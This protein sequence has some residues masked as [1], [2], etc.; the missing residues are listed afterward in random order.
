MSNILKD[1]TFLGV[2][3]REWPT[4]MVGKFS[5]KKLVICAGGA[6]VWDDLALLG[7]RGGD[8]QEWDVMCVNDVVMHYPGQVRHFFSNDHRLMPHWIGA[9]RPQ[10][11]RLYGQ[12]QHTHSCR[13]GGKHTWP[14]PGHGTSALGATYTGIALGYDRIVLCGVP[15]DNSPNYFSPSWELRNFER[16]VGTKPNGEMQYWQQA[17]DKCFKGRVKSMSGR[18][19]EL[20]GSP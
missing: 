14:W 20:L 9:R 17:R 8:N 13:V 12:I 6:C 1:F 4:D 3:M 2:T 11:V 19:R 7:V 16:E 18:T 5:G 10:Y 15:L